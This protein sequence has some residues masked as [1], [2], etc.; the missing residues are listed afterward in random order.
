MVV[1]K[2]NG[3]GI[4]GSGYGRGNG[5]IQKSGI[6]QRLNLQLEVSATG[7]DTEDTGIEINH[8]NLIDGGEEA[9]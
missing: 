5:L 8:V 7:G 6:A 1:I 4:E 9:L 3:A 2:L